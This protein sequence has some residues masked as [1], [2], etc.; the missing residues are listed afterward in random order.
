[1]FSVQKNKI[2]LR[3][4]FKN[5]YRVMLMIKKF[6]CFFFLI[7]P[8]PQKCSRYKKIKFTLGVFFGRIGRQKMFL[9]IITSAGKMLS[10]PKNIFN[11]FCRNLALSEWQIRFF[12]GSY[13]IFMV[14]RAKFGKKKFFR[15]FS[16]KEVELDLEKFWDLEKFLRSPWACPIFPFA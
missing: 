5:T 9:D 4:F 10:L 14:C 3:G 13:T 1:M 6:F 16:T 7:L 2:F 11:F 15:F 8:S 12:R